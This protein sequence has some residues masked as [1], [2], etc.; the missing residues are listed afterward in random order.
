[1]YFTSEL[2]ELVESLCGAMKTACEQAGAETDGDDVTRAEVLFF[3]LYLMKDGGYYDREEFAEAEDTIGWCASEDQWDT[4]VKMF[5]V[6]SED[7]YLSQPPETI[8]FMQDADNALYESGIDLGC[9]DAVMDV[10]KAIGEIIVNCKG[11]YDENRD[12][13]LKK[14]VAM[15]DKYQNEHSNNPERRKTSVDAPERV[16]PSK[17]GVS[18]PKK[19]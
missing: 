2:S 11:F 15:V 9:V 4:A 6:D 10:Y 13:R 19:S 12:K 7:H 3:A 16:I 8:V 14:F 17:K 5:R 1:M 18:A